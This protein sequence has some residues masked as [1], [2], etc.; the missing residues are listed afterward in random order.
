MNRLALI[1]AVARAIAL[2]L[3]VE[4]DTLCFAGEPARYGNG[5][6]RVCVVPAHTFPA[7]HGFLSEANAAVEAV[8][9][10]QRSFMTEGD[11]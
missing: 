1:E 10:F 3:G 8:E 6:S 7:W 9:L 11:A 4:P 2:R 5:V